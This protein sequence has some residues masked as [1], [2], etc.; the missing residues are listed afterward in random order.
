MVCYIFNSETDVD[1]SIFNLA[2]FV[3]Q[4]YNGKRMANSMLGYEIQL[5]TFEA[6]SLFLGCKVEVNDKNANTLNEYCMVSSAERYPFD[7]IKG[8]VCMISIIS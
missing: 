7:A 1:G 8:E 2:T 3:L 5:N 6:V 4:D